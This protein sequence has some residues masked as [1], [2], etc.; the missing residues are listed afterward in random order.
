MLFFIVDPGTS[1]DVVA[2]VVSFFRCLFRVAFVFWFLLRGFVSC[3]RLLISGR[4]T[5]LLGVLGRLGGVRVGLLVTLLLG[6]V[7]GC[8]RVFFAVLF[9][10]VSPPWYLCSLLVVMILGWGSSLVLFL[11]FCSRFF[12]VFVWGLSCWDVS[13]WLLFYW[14]SGGSVFCCVTPVVFRCLVALVHS[15]GHS[16]FWSMSGGYSSCVVFFVL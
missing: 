15:G 2:R 3:S 6:L 5:L 11:V 9:I 4:G 16:A 14:C 1:S 13:A 12:L 8:L 7:L 10:G